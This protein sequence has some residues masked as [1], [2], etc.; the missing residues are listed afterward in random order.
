MTKQKKLNPGNKAPKSET[1]PTGRQS[2]N[3][4][5]SRGK[6]PPPPPPVDP[7][8]TALRETADWI[9]RGE[10]EVSIREAIKVLF[11]NQDSQRLLAD[12]FEYIAELA[13]ANPELRRTWHIAAR[14]ELYRRAL[15]IHDFKTCRDI[16]RDLGQ[17]EGLYP[18]QAPTRSAKPA[19]AYGDTA[20]PDLE[21]DGYPV[22]Q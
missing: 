7:R 13:G 17:L 19:D 6:T 22:I 2:T 8:I 11:P 5:E 18:K 14:R 16:L 21:T 12:A 10:N 3:N 4:A 15:E 9:L 20:P 1:G